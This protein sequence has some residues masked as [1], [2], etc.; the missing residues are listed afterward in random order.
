M[1]AALFEVHCQSQNWMKV[2]CMNVCWKEEILNA[3]FQEKQIIPV[4][5][6]IGGLIEM[7]QCKR[8]CFSHNLRKEEK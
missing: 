1:D 7:R 2:L 6:I 3:K 8:P 4:Y 5:P